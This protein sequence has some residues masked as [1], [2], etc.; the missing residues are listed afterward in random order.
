MDQN[1]VRYLGLDLSD[2]K[3]AACVMNATGEIVVEATI[4]LD[5]VTVAA[6]VRFHGVT[7]AVVETGTHSRWVALTLLDLGVGVVMADARRV[8]LVTKN[9][10][11][12]DVNDARILARLLRAD[13]TLLCP[14]HVRSVAAQ[15]ALDV[16][17]MRSTFSA[18]RVRAVN[19]VRGIAKSRTFHIASGTTGAFPE[20]ARLALPADLA[21]SL[22]P[23][24]RQ[25]EFLTREIIGCDKRI[26]S[27]AND[28]P[29][30]EIL[31][32]MYGIGVATALM[33]VLII[34]DPARF[35]SS[36]DVGAYLGLVP[37]RDQSGRLDKSLGIS[38]TGNAM[39]RRQLVNCA[40]QVCRAT[41]PD[42][43][44]K[45]KAQRILDT[46]GSK[47]RKRAAVAIARTMAVVLHRMWV[48]ST[49]WEPLQQPA[50]APIALPAR[51]TNT[52]TDAIETPRPPDRP[53][54]I[55]GDC[56]KQLEAS[57]PPTT[58]GRRLQHPSSDSTMHRAA[59]PT[60]SADRSAKGKGVGGESGAKGKPRG[61][62]PK[63][64][65]GKPPEA[66]STASELP[67][68]GTGTIARTN[69]LTC[70]QEPEEKIP[71]ATADGDRG[72]PP[73]KPATRR[74]IKQGGAPAPA[75]EGHR[76]EEN[77][78]PAP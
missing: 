15:A 76:G 34:D 22:D 71:S 54:P 59:T 21:A 49:A 78:S 44:L 23:K 52:F 39:L 72:G 65:Q 8:E 17:K 37:R 13:P 24:L 50:Q 2:R 28:Y 46:G 74:K 48:T 12:S 5:P 19:F 66:A 45:R 51:T 26:A 1:N 9:A 58:S 10:R 55:S 57:A 75:C 31:K 69:D 35:R 14:V 4:K 36:R 63:A 67:G 70:I 25:V 30:V 16:L 73:P 60:K 32:T 6:F 3:A 64:S 18:E 20:R 43:D 40:M 68:P 11:K 77:S 38:K 62:R 7:D 61:P 33:F 47:V 29:A 53:T 42:S 56:A 27:V 41:A